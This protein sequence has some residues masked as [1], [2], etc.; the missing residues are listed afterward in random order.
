MCSS[1]QHHQNHG[2]GSSHTRP[3]RTSS[4][5]SRTHRKRH[6][7]ASVAQVSTTKARFQQSVSSDRG[8]EG[9]GFVRFSVPTPCPPG[10]NLICCLLSLRNRAG[11]SLT[12]RRSHTADRK[13][14][15]TVTGQAGLHQGGVRGGEPMDGPRNEACA[16]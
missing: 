11:A 14:C 6:I 3:D 5:R 16:Y 4:T 12:M 7:A 8:T 2:T 1:K 15:G 13:H 9:P 10:V